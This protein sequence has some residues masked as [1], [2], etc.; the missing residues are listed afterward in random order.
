[1]ASQRAHAVQREDAGRFRRAG[2]KERLGPRRLRRHDGPDERG[3]APFPE[4]HA[5]GV[6][7]R[8]FPGGPR[9]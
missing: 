6:R 2:E 9:G 8:H 3:D 4:R 7:E 5:E 1:M